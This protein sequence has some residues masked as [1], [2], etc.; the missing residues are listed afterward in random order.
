MWSNDSKKPSSYIFWPFFKKQI[1]LHTT[2]SVRNVFNSPRN[3][4]EP[5]GWLD[6]M[7]EILRCLRIVT[8]RCLNWCS[9]YPILRCLKWFS[10]FFG[11]FNHKVFVLKLTQKISK[12]G[13]LL[14]NSSFL[15]ES[16][17]TRFGLFLNVLL[18]FF[19]PKEHPLKLILKNQSAWVWRLNWRCL[20]TPRFICGVISSFLDLCYLSIWIMGLR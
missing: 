14:Q 20:M 4:L 9:R 11:F 3:L 15:L 5:L 12:T 6:L 7:F 18:V 8:W 16:N 1:A 13:Q 17:S 19:L 10:W 2:I